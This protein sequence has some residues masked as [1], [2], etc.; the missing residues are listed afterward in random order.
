ME[1]L[2]LR[3]NFMNTGCFYFINDQ[4]FSDFPDPLLMAN[5]ESILG[6]SHDRPCFYAFLDNRTGL[7][8]MIPI[9][10]NTAKYRYHYTKKVEKYGSCDTIV[11]G[12]VL[13]HEKAFLIQNMCPLTHKYIKNEYLDPIASI[14]V[15]IDGVSEKEIISKAKRVLALHRKGIKLIF[16]NVLKIESE[17][18]K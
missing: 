12:S 11:F 1:L 17:L 14:P 10:S 15:Q 8:W 7:Y 16:P 18:L 5:H 9:S 4:Y 3:G 6:E 2:S 13:G